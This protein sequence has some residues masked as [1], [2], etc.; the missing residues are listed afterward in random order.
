MA[1]RRRGVD[2]ELARGLRNF[3]YPI[4]KS[5]ELQDKPCGIRR[6]GEDLVLWRDSQQR[7]H[8][9]ADYC[10]HRSAK[11]SLGRVSGDRLACWYHGLQFDTTGQ[12]DFIPTAPDTKPDPRLRATAYPVSEGGGLIWA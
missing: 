5:E 10:P 11:L 8:L 3:W 2:P 6:L 4:L 7:L 1:V 9:F 12:C